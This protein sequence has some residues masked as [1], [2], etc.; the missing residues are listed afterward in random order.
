LNVRNELRVAPDKHARDVQKLASAGLLGSTIPRSVSGSAGVLRQQGP[1]VPRT[2]H[3]LRGEDLT[4]W[5]QTRGIRP[6]RGWSARNKRRA[7][8][9]P[10]TDNTRIRWLRQSKLLPTPSSSLDAGLEFGSACF[11]EEADSF[12]S[13]GRDSMRGVRRA[14]ADGSRRNL[15]AGEGRAAWAPP[16]SFCPAGF[17]FFFLSRNQLRQIRGL[18]RQWWGPPPR[19]APPVP[20]VLRHC[21]HYDDV[22]LLTCS[23]PVQLVPCFEAAI[24]PSRPVDLLDARARY[25]PRLPNRSTSRAA[26]G[27]L[28]DPNPE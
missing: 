11:A 3:V 6:C 18:F 25:R 15:Q 22:P 12:C 23:I 9:E 26:V 1:T 21:I 2:A 20:I 7:Q 27:H 19:P 5:R 16:R 10:I 14:G 8:T 24:P 4:Q 13:D 17:F 28:G